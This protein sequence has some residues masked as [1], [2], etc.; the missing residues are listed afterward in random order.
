MRADP[1]NGE[2]LSGGSRQ[3]R[4]PPALFW[5]VTAVLILA[6]QGA[7]LTLA[8]PG[9]ATLI[10]LWLY[11]RSPASYVGFMWWLWFL[12]PEIRR[13]ADWLM[14]AFT[15]MSPIQLAPLAVT[16]ISAF[17]LLRRYSMLA[18]RRGV[19]VLL[20]LLGLGYGFVIGVASN[21]LLPATYDL[22]NWLYPILIG[23]QIMAYPREYPAYRDTIVRTFILGMLV[24]G[25][26]G[27]VQF[28]VMPEW[29]AMWMLGSQ[30]MSDGDPVPMGVRV[31][32]T[33]NSSGPF[34]VA[35]MGAMA[36]VV[37]APLRV[38]WLAAALGFFSFELSMV[39]AVWGGWAVALLIQFLQ[40]NG[41]MRVRIV[42][43][44]VLLA[45]LG[46][47]L[48]AIGP[49]GDRLQARVQT[50]GRLNDDNSYE[51]RKAFYASF[52][53]TAFTDM[54]G[55]GF[56]AT[57]SS[58]KLASDAGALSKYGNFD[59]GVMNVPFVLGWPGTLLYLSGMLWLFARALRT[60]LGMR[61]DKF[62]LACMSVGVSVLALMVFINTLVGTAGLL[63]YMSLLLVVS[64]AHWKKLNLRKTLPS[65]GAL[66]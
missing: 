65:T 14:G 9:M 24:M 11:F 41:K 31:F 54:S 64:A 33:M 25:A 66:Q 32:S 48:A 1:K 22:A 45:S 55:E 51:T 23:F 2:P 52:A 47:T 20:I 8:F 42:S 35:M 62:A 26:Y 59:S 13:L 21:G 5:L 57:G 44:T 16:M 17:T 56:G 60:S 39:R 36:L 49:V 37:A 34:A 40:S 38:R 61:D 50:M 28:F 7:V 15:P 19:P 12:S 58:T 4:L 46:V 53:E 29:D 6:H 18:Q 43:V 30:M 10:G 63:L 27:L 3:E